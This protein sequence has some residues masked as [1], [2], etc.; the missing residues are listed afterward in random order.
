M[1]ELSLDEDKVQRSGDQAAE[2]EE[3]ALVG[4]RLEDVRVVRVPWYREKEIAG[5]LNMVKGNSPADGDDVSRLGL[6]DPET[7][8][9]SYR[10]AI[11]AGMLYADHYRL[12]KQDYV[13]LLIDVPAFAEVMADS[14]DNAKVILA[15]ISAALRNVL[16]PGWAIARIGLCCF[17]CF[18]QRESMGQV[19]AKL[20]TVAGMLPL[21]WKQQGIQGVPVLTHAVA[22][23]SEVLSL[24][25]MLQLLIRRLNNAEK[26]AFGDKPYTEDRITLRRDVLDSISERVVISDPETYELVYMNQ[27]ARKDVGVDA[28]ASL[29]GCRCYQT[30]E[31]FDTPCRDCPNLMLRMD[32]AF[33]ANHMNHKTGENLL[34]RS[35]L[36]V[37]E[38]R[39]LK[40]TIAFNLNEYLDA[41]AKERELFY[42]EMRANEAISR[43]MQES[44]PAKGIDKTISSIA[45]NMQPERFLIFEE[46]DDNTVSATYEWTAPGV[47]PLQAEL[48]SIPKTELRALYTQFV[49]EHLVMVRDMDAFQ[50]EHPDFSFRIHGV[51]SFVSG[52]LLL[53]N[54]TEGFTLVVNPSEESFNTGSI[55]YSTLTDFIAVMVR[56]RNSIRELE[57]QSKIDQLTGAGNRR[58]LEQRIRAWQGDGVLGAISIDL[59]GLKN[60]N[61]T[62]GASRRRCADQ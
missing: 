57:K 11:E 44:D 51:H 5:T 1:A 15:K 32:R 38:N 54:Q 16:M 61:D 8:L 42:Q 14:A 60:T 12:K 6:S 49:S 39:T 27:A 33:S 24:D 47:V 48:Q 19:E 25:E 23:G 28:D 17:L 3:L 40:M 10:G 29:E 50:K 4:G 41:M 43:G 30:L 9:L 56:N 55:L 36:T 20:E 31:G 35:F 7:D 59:N 52:Q 26:E 13:G 45:G 2:V 58:A 18:C 34:V 37:W 53:Q 22:Y 21:L 46:R 62:P